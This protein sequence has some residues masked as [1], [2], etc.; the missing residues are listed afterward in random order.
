MY[1]TKQTVENELG[2]PKKSEIY[3][4]NCVKAA[5]ENIKARTK[6]LLEHAVANTW[7]I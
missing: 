7:P 4:T 2:N 1:K 3:V 5:M 6:N